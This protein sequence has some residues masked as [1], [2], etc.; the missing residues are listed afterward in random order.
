[1]NYFQGCRNYSQDGFKNLARWQSIR[2]ANIVTFHT[3]FTI[4]VKQSST[5]QVVLSQRPLSDKNQSGLDQNLPQRIV[6]VLVADLP[7]RQL[8]SR[9]FPR[10]EILSYQ[11]LFFYFIY[12]AIKYFRHSGTVRSCSCTTIIR[13][14]R[15]SCSGTSCPRR[16]LG[17]RSASQWPSPWSGITSCSWHQHYAQSI[18]RILRIGSFSRQI[19]SSLEKQGR[20]MR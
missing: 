15:R 2:H 8:L 20:S 9:H 7:N 17:N 12:W 18:P 3:A 6:A 19:L 1:M 16:I 14:R 11:L 10:A 5:A 4:K 13:R